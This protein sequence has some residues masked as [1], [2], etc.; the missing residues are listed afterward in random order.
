[1]ERPVCAASALMSDVLPVPGGPCSRKPSFWGYPGMANLPR[2]WVKASRRSSRAALSGWK[3][4]VNV[5]SSES[6]YLGWV[7]DGGRRMGDGG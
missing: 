4:L 5:L 1:M 6:L 7:V 3:R 2:P